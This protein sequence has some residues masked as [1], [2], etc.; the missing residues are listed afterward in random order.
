LSERSPARAPAPAGGRLS[1][2]RGEPPP[3]T[4]KLCLNYLG[5]YRNGVSFVLAGLD[6]VEKAKLIEDTFWPLVGGG[7]SF[8]ETAVSLVRSDREDPATH[9]AAAR[10]STC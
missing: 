9:E 4:A 2:V 3:A 5:G 8:A 7:E 1:A 6:V 10:T